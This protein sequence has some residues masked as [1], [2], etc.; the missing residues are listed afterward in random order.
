MCSPFSLSV[1]KG[2]KWRAPRSSRS[3]L[4][5]AYAAAGA[6]RCR[7]VAW[8]F[9]VCRVSCVWITRVLPGGLLAAPLLGVAAAAPCEQRE[10]LEPFYCA[11]RASLKVRAIAERC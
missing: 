3:T 8:V 11:L 2:L 10:T 9:V 7:P 4:R 6:C 5:S 1:A